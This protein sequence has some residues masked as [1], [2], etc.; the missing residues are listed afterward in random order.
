MGRRGQGTSQ[1]Q[2]TVSERPDVSISE[3]QRERAVP[4]LREQA[5]EP[6]RGPPRAPELGAC[7]VGWRAESGTG[8]RVEARPLSTRPISLGPEEHLR[9]TQEGLARP[10][11]GVSGR[12]RGPTCFPH[13]QADLPAHLL[14]DT[15]GRLLHSKPLRAGHGV[16]ARILGRESRCLH[17]PFKSRLLSFGTQRGTGRRVQVSSVKL[18]FRSASW[19]RLAHQR[20]KRSPTHP[21]KLCPPASPPGNPMP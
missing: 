5:L 11:G 3:H 19:H 10:G 1:A 14:E 7:A 6:G 20:V 21:T 9:A 16:H 8:R 13:T 15:E 17:C 4:W 18:A 2:P 12:L